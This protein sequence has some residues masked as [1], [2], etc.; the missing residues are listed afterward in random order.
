M[1]TRYAITVHY[2]SADGRRLLQLRQLTPSK[3][4]SSFT[5]VDLT[6]N[7]ATSDYH[8][9]QIQFQRRLSRGLQALVSYTWSH[10]IDEDSSSFSFFNG[11]PQRGNADF[12]RRHNF[13]A[14]ITYDI[15]R[16]ART[17]PAA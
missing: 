5:T 17:V 2:G 10:A 13:A 7:K 16:P 6:T 14:A 11:L 3:I 4:N 12:D 15:P 1:G 9:L 8:A